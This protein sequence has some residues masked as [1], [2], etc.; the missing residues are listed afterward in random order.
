MKKI[1]VALPVV[2]MLVSGFAYSTAD[3]RSAVGYL[4]ND[5]DS[6][7]TSGIKPE[8]KPKQ[9]EV[10][11]NNNGSAIGHLPDDPDSNPTPESSPSVHS[12]IT[13]LEAYAGENT[14]K[15]EHPAEDLTLNFYRNDKYEGSANI[16]YFYYKAW[17]NRASFTYPGEGLKP[18]DIL[19][20][21]TKDSSGQVTKGKEFSVSDMS[22]PE[23]KVTVNN[24]KAGNSVTIEGETMEIASTYDIYVNGKW[25]T[26]V[27]KNKYSPYVY[28]VQVPNLNKGDIVTVLAKDISESGQYTHGSVTTTVQ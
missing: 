9:E 17:G 24:L 27:K 6:N 23:D 21:D 20:V 11:E 16:Y 1:F 5:P 7:P 26:T 28:S 22:R 8:E 15:V 19:R 12:K 25:V 2:T 13:I 4:P 18:G 14:I 3:A 10:A